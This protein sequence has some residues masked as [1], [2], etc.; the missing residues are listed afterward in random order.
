MGGRGVNI[1]REDHL[2]CSPDKSR[3]GALESRV[4]QQTSLAP[5]RSAAWLLN[6]AAR[7]G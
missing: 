1:R 5:L 3:V 2:H 7:P 6:R 4:R